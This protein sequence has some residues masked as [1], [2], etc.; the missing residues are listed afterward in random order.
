MAGIGV[1]AAS[2]ATPLSVTTTSPLPLAPLNTPYSTTLAATGGTGSYTWAVASGSTLPSWLSLNSSTGVL[3]GTPTTDATATF[4]VTVT[5]AASSTA[6][7]GQ[8]TL[9]AGNGGT[10]PF[11]LNMTSGSWTVLSTPSGTSQPF[12]AQTTTTLTGTVAPL[13]GVIT[14]ATLSLPAQYGVCS[15]AAG[16]CTNY[17]MDEVDPGTA[18]GSINSSGD[19]TLNDS[20]SYTLDVTQPVTAQCLSTPINMVFQS[21]APYDTTTGNVTLSASNYN[22]PDFTG[23]DGT[24]SG[25]T[26]SCGIAQG[27]P[28]VI[29]VNGGIY[30]YGV[31]GSTNNTT[32]LNL[33]GTGLPIPPPPGKATTNTLTAS[34]VSP[35]LIQTPVTL[36]DTISF[37]SSTA[38]NAT[39][40]VNFVANGA[41]IGTE[42]V[43]NG[44]AT[45]TTTALPSQTIQLT[46]VY[47]GDFNY[48]GSTSATVPYTIQALPSVTLNLPT[49]VELSS[50]TPT[51]FSVTL[52]NPGTGADWSNDLYLD[53][54]F[55]GGYLSS[56]DVTLNYQD[57][58]GNW[59]PL[60]SYGGSPYYYFSGSGTSPCGMEASSVLAGPRTVA[61]RQPR[62]VHRLRPDEQ[63]RSRSPRDQGD[64]L[65]WKLLRPAHM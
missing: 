47:S 9:Y 25:P 36:T 3:S 45:F 1:G 42:P 52:T 27:G 4:A 63:C 57:G 58:A 37:G 65:E 17:F 10:E 43:S 28:G 49:T 38:T 30:P 31:A 2:A 14:D 32:T 53:L 13:T 24:S 48:A 16:G 51:P 5:D 35:Q 18:T 46:A 20:L 8:L 33:Q 40:T 15:K 19:I 39:G 26:D 50:P 22:I 64:P 55:P 34:P 54:R 12:P 6:T 60:T 62:G 7:S 21:T 41:V 23:L 11:S 29:G 61:H 44:S 59:C 56:P